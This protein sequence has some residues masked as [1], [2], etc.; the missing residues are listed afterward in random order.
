ML[1]E[2]AYSNPAGQIRIGGV[3]RGM[4]TAEAFSRLRVSDEREGPSS[5]S[6]PFGFSAGVQ[7]PTQVRLAVGTVDWFPF[8]VQTA[9]GRPIPSRR[10][11]DAKVEG[12]PERVRFIAFRNHYSSC[13]TVKA[14]VA[15]SGGASG[16][17]QT[18]L[19]TYK[20]MRSPHFEDDA[21]DWKVIELPDRTRNGL[22]LDR[23]TELRLYLFQPSAMFN[24]AHYGIRSL[25]AYS[26][27]NKESC[28]RA[29]YRA[30]L[31]TEATAKEDSAGEPSLEALIPGID[32]EAA[33]GGD[34]AGGI[35]VDELEGV[36][37]SAV[38]LAR[39]LRDVYRTRGQ[40]ED[41]VP[42]GFRQAFDN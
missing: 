18:V 11:V 24:G 3:A 16:P 10:I 37:A 22:E 17:W 6:R 1:S 7:E 42:K 34:G 19:T 2:D 13:V 32:L 28:L 25:A 29:A 39:A 30:H 27:G 9:E 15:G 41:P 5:S 36:V 38:D 21:E 14:R 31:P 33:T 20:L 26:D 23:V 4:A 40:T 12:R 8:P 35:S